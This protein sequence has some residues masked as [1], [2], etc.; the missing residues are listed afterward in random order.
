[1]GL[2]LTLPK[3]ANGIGCD[4]IDAYWVI[5]DLRYE[6]QESGLFAIFWLNCYPT[7]E[8]YELTGHSVGNIGI[9]RPILAVYN[10]KLYEFIGLERV[11]RLFPDGIPVSSDEQKTV[12]YNYIKST[13]GLPFEDV[14]EEEVEDDTP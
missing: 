14:F 2:K 7:R 1:M 5:E 4:F 11:E 6:M 9:G 12:L 8:A 13:S 10:G 3:T